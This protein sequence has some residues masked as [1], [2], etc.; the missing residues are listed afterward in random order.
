MRED[1]G[2]AGPEDVIGKNDHQLRW[3]DNADLYRADDLAVLESGVGR[4]AYDEP[5]ASPSG[6]HVWLRTS[7]VPLRSR[8]GELMGVL[9]IYEDVT[10]RRRVEQRLSMAIEVAR[11]VLWELDFVNDRLIFDPAMLPMLGLGAAEAPHSLRGWLELVHPDEQ[12]LFQERVEQALSSAN[13][14]FDFEYRL[15][16]SVGRHEWIHTRGRVVERGEGGQPLLAV[17]TSVNITARK[18]IEA[19]MRTS[20]ERFRKLASMLRLMCDN[21]PDM[22][23]AKD[24]EGRF[25]FANKATCERL[26]NAVDTA[27]PLGRTDAFFA[28]RERARHPDDPEW[29][30]FGELAPHGTVMAVVDGTASVLEE[31][32]N[33]KGKRHLPGCAERTIHR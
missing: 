2:K 7:K 3:I 31:S 16:V 14:V 15:S 30:T 20:E 12:S 28:Q 29:H 23:W 22:I 10:E 32:G 6:Q 33:A 13:P 18:Q 25:V 5:Q 8:D 26:L 11:V 21:V 27:E 19:A 17:G 4:L 9:G 1:A 24:M